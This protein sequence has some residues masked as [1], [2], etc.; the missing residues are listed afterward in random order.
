MSTIE[1]FV[2]DGKSAERRRK[3][4][5]RASRLPRTGKNAKKKGVGSKRDSTDDANAGSLKP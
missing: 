5:R 3:R 2:R 1:E 4:T